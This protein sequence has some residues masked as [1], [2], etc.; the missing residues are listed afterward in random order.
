MF[1]LLLVVEISACD[2]TGSP[3]G[4]C[5]LSIELNAIVSS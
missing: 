3:S 5:E 1:K 2:Q 4:P